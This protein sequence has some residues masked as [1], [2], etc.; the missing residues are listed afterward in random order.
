[1]LCYQIKIFGFVQGVFFRYAA[2]EE[3]EKLGLTGFAKNLNDGS[4]EIIVCGEK[5]KTAE[6]IKW[7]HS[8]PAMGK[9]ERVEEKEI[10]FIEFK[11]FDIL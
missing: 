1:M 6:F 9:I 7:C 11:S 2:K 10:E 8:G 4:V 5:E 3:A